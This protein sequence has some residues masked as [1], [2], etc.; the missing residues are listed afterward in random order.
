MSV[1]DASLT[2]DVEAV[3][4]TGS[5]T[6]FFRLAGGIELD[7]F[8][9][10]W[11]DHAWTDAVSSVPLWEKEDFQIT[12]ADLNGTIESF[13]LMQIRQ[14]LTY[15]VD[16]SSVDVGETFHLRITT[17]A[18]AHNAIAGPPS[19]GPNS[20]GAYFNTT[21]RLPVLDFA[22]L[23]TL[24]TPDPPVFAGTPATAVACPSGRPIR[25]P[26]CSSS[27]PRPTRVSNRAVRR[28]S[29]LRAPVAAWV[30]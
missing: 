12:I 10:S 21:G 26:A 18:Y 29:P 16:L 9:E 15:E 27:A 7:G 5:P 19:E 23:D 4:N 17:T 25:K 24:E 8:A 13:V 2:F 3:D 22:G 14:P 1:I 30:W 28:S 20:A 6:T 11:E